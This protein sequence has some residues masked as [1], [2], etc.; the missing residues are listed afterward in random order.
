MKLARRECLSAI[1]LS[2]VSSGCL[3]DY[4]S[5][6][7][8]RWRQQHVSGYPATDTEYV[9]LSTPSQVKKV[10]K[11]T[12]EEISGWYQTPDSDTP[13]FETTTPE[14][15]DDSI[16]IGSQEA[17]VFSIDKETGEIEWVYPTRGR[18]RGQV[19][20]A[21]GTVYAA[22]SDGVLHAIDSS[23]AEP[24]WKYEVEIGVGV[25]EGNAD[26]IELMPRKPKYSDG[27]VFFGGFNNNV[28]AVTEDGERNWSVSGTG[29]IFDD[30]VVTD[31]K[32]YFGS[33]SSDDG[34]KSVNKETGEVIWD[35]SGNMCSGNCVSG[36]VS[37]IIVGESRV[38]A[39]VADGESYIL[40]KDGRFLD[41]I[42]YQGGMT[43]FGGN[44]YISSYY[45]RS[46]DKQGN[47]NWKYRPSNLRDDE[48]YRGMSSDSELIYLQGVGRLLAVES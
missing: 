6:V 44:L 26:L 24:I 37:E 41:L 1:A 8:I 4:L 5:P 25:S 48:R 36:E 43:L 2:A 11:E 21:D 12:G 28:Y 13:G 32:V 7:S 39:G 35:S 29:L 17:G 27:L 14:I 3:S 30:P 16:Y 10:N 20:Y 42:E 31:N 45:L 9:Y 33:L 34:I 46:Y 47:L 18:V 23:S 22:S 38:Y 40:N 15:G 19:E